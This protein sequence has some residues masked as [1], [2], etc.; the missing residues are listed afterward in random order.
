MGDVRKVSMHMAKDI[1]FLV[2]LIVGIAAAIG[3][4]V[5]LWHGHWIEGMALALAF[6]TCIVIAFRLAAKRVIRAEIRAV[7][8]AVYQLATKMENRMTAVDDELAAIQ[9]SQAQSDALITKVS[10]D[11]TTLLGLLAAVPTAGL[12]PA[13]QTALDAVAAHATLINTNLTGVD[14]SAQP[15]APAPAPAAPTA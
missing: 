9:A 6:A 3:A 15:A 12:T 11:V 4:V 5:M 1:G 2:A 14:A 8:E 13:Q 10:A 7:R